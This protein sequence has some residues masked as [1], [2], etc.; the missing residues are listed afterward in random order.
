MLATITRR[1]VQ[2][3]LHVRVVTDVSVDNLVHGSTD[4][5]ALIR[6]METVKNATV[7]YLPRIHA[8]VY[9]S[10]E[11]FA[12]ITS[13]N[14]TEGGVFSN[15]EYGVTVE[16]TALVR[17]IRFDIEQYANLGGRLTLQRLMHLNNRAIELKELLEDEQRS[18]RAKLQPA[19]EPIRRDAENNLLISRIDGRSIYGVFRDTILYLLASR[20][21]STIE[22]EKRIQQIHP[23]LCDDTLDRVI[24]GQH[25]GKLWKHQVRTAQ[26]HLKKVHLITY[27]KTRRLWVRTSTA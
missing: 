4:V 2:S 27:D 16:D 26:Q 15:L 1:G 25:F 6:L 13:A 11:N 17:T 9:I 21:M 3:S 10:E 18:I 5:A 23:D 19:S 22:L 24:E 8:K 20:S 12:L 14:F 7:T